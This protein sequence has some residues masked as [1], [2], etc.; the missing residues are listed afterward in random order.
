MV[1]NLLLTIPNEKVEDVARILHMVA[2]DIQRKNKSL[3][4]L[5]I[6]KIIKVTNPQ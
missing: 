4:P 5:K 6:M 2:S 1:S 3:Y